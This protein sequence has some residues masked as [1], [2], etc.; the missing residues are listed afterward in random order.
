MGKIKSLFLIILNDRIFQFT[1]FEF[2]VIKL[3]H[4]F[5]LKI[6]IFNN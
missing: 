4:I 5:Y 6:K 3:F 1:I 2:K